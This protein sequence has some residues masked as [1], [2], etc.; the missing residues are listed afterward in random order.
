MTRRNRA[1]LKPVRQWQLRKKPRTQSLLSLQL[2]GFLLVA[3]PLLAGLVVSAV[4]IGRVTHDS[5]Q[6]LQRSISAARSARQVHEAVADFARAA[7]QYRVLLDADARAGLDDRHQKLTQQLTAFAAMTDAAELESELAALGRQS[8]R[9]RDL[10]IEISAEEDWPAELSEPFSRLVKSGE[11]LLLLTESIS[12]RELEQLENM[13]RTARLAALLILVLAVPVAVLLAL[14]MAGFINRSIRQLD[15]G[16]RA[17]ARPEHARIEQIKSPRDLRALSVRLEWVRRRLVRSGRDRERLLAQVSHELKTPL[18][19]IREGTSL[20]ADES[21]GA[22]GERQLEITGIISSNVRRLEQQIENLLRFSRLQSGHTPAIKSGVSPDEV[23]DRVLER[24]RLNMETK[25]LAL[26]RNTCRTLTVCADSD[27]LAT[28][29]DNLVSNAI[30]FSPPGQT[31]GVDI[32]QRAGFAG[33]CVA[34]RGPGISVR[35]RHRL[36]EPFYRGT[37]RTRLSVAGSGLGLAICRDLIHAHNGRVY[38]TDHA[39]W[40]IVFVIE[41][42]LNES[43]RRKP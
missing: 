19:A 29:F 31:I 3:L 24:H 28:A 41:L 21:F 37:G 42:P 25:H 11:G 16:M 23:M 27:M 2:I 9:L 18:S 5:E 14:L 6:L 4:Q 7:R 8:R 30:K 39:D 40:S 34:D 1:S 12:G 22:L 17:L 15:R 35:D 26:Q 33:I 36:F 10:T 20:L 13:G 32:R 38:A 43:G